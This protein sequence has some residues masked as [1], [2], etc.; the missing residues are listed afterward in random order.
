MR[1]ASRRELA[2]RST[3]DGTSGRDGWEWARP[4]SGEP[5]VGGPVR[6]DRTTGWSRLEVDPESCCQRAVATVWLD[7]V[8]ILAARSAEW[9]IKAGKSI[10]AKAAR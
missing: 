9:A 5:D 10:V 4:R 6:G 2:N 7:C 1:G 3:A 8:S